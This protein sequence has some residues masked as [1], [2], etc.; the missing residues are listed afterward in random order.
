M[1]QLD[2]LT[3]LPQ[4][5]WLLLIFSSLYY[6]TAKTFLPRICLILFVRDY[7]MQTN[8]SNSVSEK[9]NILDLS[10]HILLK[11]QLMALS[12]IL[13]Q[14]KFLIMFWSE[15]FDNF[16]NSSGK[17]LLTSSKESKYKNSFSFFFKDLT[18]L[19]MDI[20][21][22]STTS[23]GEQPQATFLTGYSTK[24]TK[25][26]TLISDKICKDIFFSNIK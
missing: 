14:T 1:P 2:L 13:T 16:R 10:E 21:A 23:T 26:H 5:S 19:Q 17:S 4:I 18:S 15:K 7:E 12:N 8:I 22:L 9:P 11:K 20:S 24:R 6:L 3:Y 25:Y